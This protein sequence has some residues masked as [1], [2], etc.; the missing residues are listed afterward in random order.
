M[1]TIIRLVYVLGVCEFQFSSQA[2]E[3]SAPRATKNF[4]TLRNFCSVW[5]RLE[6]EK[7]L[8]TFF[9]FPSR[10]TTLGWRRLPSKCVTQ[11]Q[12]LFSLCED[13][14]TC[15][16]SRRDQHAGKYRASPPFFPFQNGTL[17]NDECALSESLRMPAHVE[18]LCFDEQTFS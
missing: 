14:K 12:R 11:R 9:L 18:A 6:E 7:L 3:V 16:R 17:D 13:R 5:S 10:E 15:R 1:F 2:L 8:L 4:S